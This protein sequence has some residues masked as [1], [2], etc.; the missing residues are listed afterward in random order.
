MTSLD[1]ATHTIRRK[2]YAPHYTQSN[3][4]QFQSEMREYTFDVIKVRHFNVIGGMGA[5]TFV[6]SWKLGRKDFGWVSG[7]IPALDGWP[8]YFVLL[9]LS[10][11]SI[12]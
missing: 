4:T 9:W 2:S 3:V 10:P 11:R 1:H 8:G 5:E 12:R 7:S 6:D